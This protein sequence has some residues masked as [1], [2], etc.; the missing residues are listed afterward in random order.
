MKPVEP[1]VIDANVLV[2]AVN[3]DAPQYLSS[4]ALLEAALD[5]AVTLYV[6]SQ[7]LCEFYSLI[8]NPKR[9]TLARS[10]KEGVLIIKDLLALPGL[11][12]LSTPPKA[13]TVM[14]ELLKRHPVTGSG[15]FD[16]QI[17][18]AMQANNIPRIYTFNIKDF[19][20]FPEP[21]VVM[22]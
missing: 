15:I 6:T 11:H 9:I 19:K 5:P 22:P 8:T 10:T 4:R 18:A 21:T 20:V 2:Y 1:G 14:L 12:L 16:L 3:S 7:I 13:V 17:I